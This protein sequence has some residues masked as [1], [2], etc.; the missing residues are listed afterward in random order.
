MKD[1][2]GVVVFPQ[3]VNS[4]E[5]LEREQYKIMYSIIY[6]PKLYTS[7]YHSSAHLVQQFHQVVKSLYIIGFPWYGTVAHSTSNHLILYTISP[8]TPLL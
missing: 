4:R 3:A 2:S 1:D 5:E 6:L 8:F 7:V